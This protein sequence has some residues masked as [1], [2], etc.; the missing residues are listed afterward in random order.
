MEKKSIQI[1]PSFFNYDSKGK[2]KGKSSK[3]ETKKKEMMVNVN[4]KS[5][6]EMLL[7]KLKEYKKNKTKKVMQ[8]MQQQTPGSNLYKN[9][10]LEKIKKRKQKTENNVILE[11]NNIFNPPVHNNT[12]IQSVKHV[13]DTKNVQNMPSSQLFSL[14]MPNR[15]APP[16]QHDFT[17]SVSNPTI[18]EFQNRTM[19]A[20]PIK[21]NK[22]IVNKNV[23]IEI[24]R[25]L[26]VGVN[27][28]RKKVGI[29]IKNNT[30]RR[31]V[32]LEKSKIKKESIRNVKNTLKKYNLI[33]HGTYAPN[34]LL[35]EIYESSYL[36][37]GVKNNNSENIIHNFHK[38]DE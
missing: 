8:E 23:E 7:Q 36:I 2:S 10:F 1:T 29:F 32:E 34:S 14:N 24:Q 25:K 6:K 19:K 20:S 31:N 27:K 9:D 18:R 16:I 33:K 28:S 4:G 11:S 15:V 13:V 22:R 37:G 5:V 30:T 12:Q 3:S 35:R 17:K 21:N 38:Q 26:A